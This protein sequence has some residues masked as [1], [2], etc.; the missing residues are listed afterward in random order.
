MKW[1]SV[2]YIVV[3]DIDYFTTISGLQI[4]I[5]TELLKF[6]FLNTFIEL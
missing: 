2:P 5:L 1:F 6:L 4:K 3:T